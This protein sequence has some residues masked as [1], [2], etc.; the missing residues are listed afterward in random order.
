MESRIERLENKIEELERKLS[1]KEDR[2]KGDGSF[3]NIRSESVPIKVVNNSQDGSSLYI[4]VSRKWIKLFSFTDSEIIFG[5]NVN[6]KKDLKAQKG[7]VF[8]GGGAKH[9]LIIPLEKPLVPRKGSMCVNPAD[10]D[11]VIQYNGTAWKMMDGNEP[12]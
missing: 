4:K 12:T 10:A 6:F 5:K 2:K 9:G 8:V 11:E 7:S 1:L 3:G